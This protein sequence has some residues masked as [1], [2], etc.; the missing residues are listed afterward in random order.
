MT[1]TYTTTMDRIITLQGHTSGHRLQ[2]S[3]GFIVM[4]RSRGDIGRQQL[5]V[6]CGILVKLQ[7]QVCGK[8][9]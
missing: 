5:L 2:T 3:T 9:R 8:P 7:M 4:R 1:A 6:V